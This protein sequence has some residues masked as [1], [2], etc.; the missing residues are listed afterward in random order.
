VVSILVSVNSGHDV[1]R[2]GVDIAEGE[3]VLVEGDRI[4][5][6]EV[7]LMSAVGV[8]KV[9]VYALPRIA[10]LSTGNEVSLGSTCIQ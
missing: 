2:I 10:V 5:P 4:G 7:G 9:S 1:R 3:P 6:P 8:T